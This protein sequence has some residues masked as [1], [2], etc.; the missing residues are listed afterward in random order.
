MVPQN[1]AKLSFKT[2]R[3]IYSES[4]LKTVTVKKAKEKDIISIK[5]PTQPLSINELYNLIKVDKRM[6]LLE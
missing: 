2:M 6:S 3:I 5:T 1:P 4:C